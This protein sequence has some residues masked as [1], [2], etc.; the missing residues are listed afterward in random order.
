MVLF[1]NLIEPTCKIYG[2]WDIYLQ[3]KFVAHTFACFRWEKAQWPPSQYGG[4]AAVAA[5]AMVGAVA[6]AGS[7]PSSGMLANPEPRDSASLTPGSALSLTPNSSC[8]ELRMEG[9]H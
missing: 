8:E 3:H 2:H 7:S 5:G 4:A 9:Q 1:P 6:L